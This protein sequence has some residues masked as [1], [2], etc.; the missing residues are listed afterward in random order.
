[1]LSENSSAPNRL[2]VSVRPTAGK[3]FAAASLESLEL[4]MAP[5]SREYAECTIR[6]TNCGV[7]AGVAESRRIDGAISL[8][9]RPRRRR[10]RPASPLS[11]HSG[12]CQR[13]LWAL[14]TGAI[15]D[16]PA[17]AARSPSLLGEKVPK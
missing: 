15:V 9:Y 16:S 2:P 14:H 7:A 10:A 12:R 4:V 17:A 3:P 1:S 8:S 13:L 11:R 6:C 5:S